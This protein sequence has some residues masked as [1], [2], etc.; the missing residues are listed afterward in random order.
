MA[1]INFAHREIT[2]KVVY[3]GAPKAGCNTNLQVLHDTVRASERSRLHEFGPSEEEERTRYF[4]Y[5][6]EGTAP[7]TGF[8]TRFRVYS[9][10]GGLLHP[11]HREEVLKNT[12]AIVFVADARRGCDQ[13]NVDALLELERGLAE[14]GIEMA[15]LPMVIQVNHTDADGASSPADVTRDLNPY[16]F[17]VVAAVARDTV[18][19][20]ATHKTI[21]SAT[22]SRI[23]DNLSGRESSVV[24][25]AVHR[26]TREN[27]DEVVR[28]HLDALSTAEHQALLS[29][30]YATLTRG[31]EYEIP[32]QPR[33]FVGMRPVE[34]R[35][36]AIE[37]DRVFVDLVME[38]ISGGQPAILPLVL[39]NRPADIEPLITVTTA[40]HTPAPIASVAPPTAMLPDKIEFSGSSARNAEAGVQEI[41]L[42]IA[43]AGTAGGL[44]A[45]LLLGFLFWA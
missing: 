22:V 42:W 36:T 29:G 19:V 17:P 43:A 15:A 23:Q 45:G 6:P 32:F 21:A 1:L 7:I 25:T 44:T 9:M 11:V 31:A 14:I 4:E 2:A 10:P 33:E 12:D 26:S 24:L 18:G 40:S 35:A 30:D 5:V 3:F 39:V 20:V 41:S 8:S 34:L 38:R 13:R 28:R 16:D 27:D 37:G